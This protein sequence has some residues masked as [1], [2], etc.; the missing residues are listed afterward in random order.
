MESST[1]GHS[2]R[3]LVGP[4]DRLYVVRVPGS[5]QQ[6]ELSPQSTL[7][8]VLS[9]A[10]STS[11]DFS[12]SNPPLVAS[13]TN[14]QSVLTA[15]I[16]APINYPPQS[17]DATRNNL[18]R[19]AVNGNR[20]G[21]IGLQYLCYP[22]PGRT[23]IRAS[24][25]VSGD[26]G[27]RLRTIE[28]ATSTLAASSVIDQQP[29]RRFILPSSKLTTVDP[30]LRTVYGPEQDSVI[31]HR[32]P[33]MLYMKTDDH[34]LSAYQ[35]LVRQ[36]IELFQASKEDIEAS[37]QGRNRPIVLGQVGIRCRHCAGQNPRHRKPAA[38]YFPRKVMS[39]IDQEVGDC[40]IPSLFL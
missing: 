25:G 16:A 15:N 18:T 34:N 2:W 39:S 12:L 36:Q 1:D 31:P 33:L 30:P 21:T 29:S 32:Q 20:E 24:S 3:V 27:N 37:A 4:D 17:H 7:L 14:D 8:V 5:N 9:P 13:I 23:S 38:C 6:Q 26:C 22:E 40:P 19:S 10:P 35:C 28:Q 11:H